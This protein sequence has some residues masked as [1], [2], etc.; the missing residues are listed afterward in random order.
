MS[1]HWWLGKMVTKHDIPI[2]SK[3]NQWKKNIWTSESKWNSEY[4]IEK[5][6]KGIPIQELLLRIIKSDNYCLPCFSTDF[7]HRLISFWTPDMFLFQMSWSNLIRSAIKSI[8]GGGINKTIASKP[9]K[10][11]KTISLLP[12]QKNFV[13]IDVV[14]R[15]PTNRLLKCNRGKTL[16]QPASQWDNRP[17]HE[18]QK[19]LKK[20]WDYVR[21]AP[22]AGT[23]LNRWTEAVYVSKSKIDGGRR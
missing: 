9:L 15:Q 21:L 13:I 4:V 20:R 6:R 5:A 23:R 17:K 14:R 19:N 8:D 12:G 2:C 22:V 11:R 16:G 7:S 18:N 3:I 1:I 10:C